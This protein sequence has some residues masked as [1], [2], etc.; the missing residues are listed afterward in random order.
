[1]NAKTEAT[2]R[3]LLLAGKPVAFVARAAGCAASTVSMRKRRLEAEGAFDDDPDDAGE[4]PETDEFDDDDDAD[5]VES[6]PQSP[7]VLAARAELDAMKLQLERD[8]IQLELDQ[9][10]RERRAMQSATESRQSDTAALLPALFAQLQEGQRQSSEAQA[11][12]MQLMVEM[13]KRDPAPPSDGFAGLTKALP[14]L[15][16]LLDFVTEL[17]GEPQP[18]STL[19]RVLSHMVNLTNRTPAPGAAAPV[20]HQAPPSV[21][22]IPGTAAA[23]AAA[24]PTAA[25]LQRVGGGS[26]RLPGAER[27]DA[28]LAHLMQEMEIGSEAEAV[29]DDV[30]DHLGLLP[31]EVREAIESAPFEVLLAT[32]NRW[33]DP[34]ITNK[35]AGMI[36]SAERHQRWVGTFLVA[37]RE[38]EQPE[39][40]FDDD[41]APAAAPEANG[42][43]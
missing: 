16:G 7:A 20:Q 10:A 34:A 1:M 14:L 22:T 24:P 27:V 17:R 38:P 9:V 33:A 40:R 43:A 31:G 26:S 13:V 4:D 28:F 18:T 3:K 25:D 11:R 15:T 29:A 36:G 39:G 12:Q 30:A 32:L 8:R 19:D 42:T 2:I 5:E 37:L 23:S 6:P 41:L 35:L 21:P